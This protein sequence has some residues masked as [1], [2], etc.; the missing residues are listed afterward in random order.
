MKQFFD[1]Q[2]PCL[3]ITST[4]CMYYNFSATFLTRFYLQLCEVINTQC[5]NLK[6][7]LQCGLHYLLIHNE[8]TFSTIK[9]CK[10]IPRLS[11][12]LYS[13]YCVLVLTLRS[14]TNTNEIQD[15][16][17]AYQKPA[18]LKLSDLQYSKLQ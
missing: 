4:L 6:I 1:I 12:I 18:K 11:N 7:T 3:N 8:E 13:M 2:S 14:A 5:E 16:F 9:S 15:L 10:G 17:A